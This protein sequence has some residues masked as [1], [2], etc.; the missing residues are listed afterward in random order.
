MKL[1]KF[2]STYKAFTRSVRKY[3]KYGTTPNVE[4]FGSPTINNGVVSGFSGS[5]YLKTF[6]G[7]FTVESE[8]AD[9]WEMVF[10]VKYTS[11]SNYQ[12]IWCQGTA[13]SSKFFIKETGKIAL[14]ISNSSTSVNVVS[15]TGTTTLTNNTIYYFKAEFTGS[16]Y[17]IYRSSNGTSWTQE[18]SANSSTKMT[19]RG[20]NAIG[21]NIGDGTNYKQFKGQIDLTKSY[22]KANGKIWWSG[23]LPV[24]ATSSDYDY[25]EGITEYDGFNL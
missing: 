11:D 17:K 9:T 14:D 8:F 21:A 1:F 19:D 12:N 2:S 16:A 20:K 22:I 10:K 23:T 5:N 7:Q 6:P 24:A 15:I 4:I 3:Y 25:Y 18:A 13:Y